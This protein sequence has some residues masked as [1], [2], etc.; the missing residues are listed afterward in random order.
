MD[1]EQLVQE[2]RPFQEESG[3]LG[4]PIVDICVEEA[5]PGDSSSSFI[6][7]VKAPWVDSLD[8]SESLD[9]LFDVLWRTTT[10]DVREKVFSIQIIDGSDE[11]HC[12]S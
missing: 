11:L 10:K 9:F 1:R 5:F 6:V 7:Q 2:L 4:R 3:S 12:M 8:C